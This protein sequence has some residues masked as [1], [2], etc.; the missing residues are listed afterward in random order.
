MSGLLTMSAY[1]YNHFVELQ[2]KA[3]MPM[4]IFLKMCFLGRCT[5]I[6]QSPVL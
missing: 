2:R 5:G 6:V 4:A 1:P 3:L